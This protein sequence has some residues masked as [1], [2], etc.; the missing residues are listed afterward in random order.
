MWNS[1]SQEG[2]NFWLLIA[3]R[4]RG[5]AGRAVIMNDRRDPPNPSPQLPQHEREVAAVVPVRHLSI[6]ARALPLLACLC[7]AMASSFSSSEFARIFESGSAFGHAAALR[8]LALA[9]AA[10]AARGRFTL[11]LSGGSMMAQLGP[12]LVQAVCFTYLFNLILDL[13]F[14]FRSTLFGRLWPVLSAIL[15][16]AREHSFDHWHIFLADERCVSHE[17][18]DSNFALVK[19]HF[20]DGIAASDHALP[21]ANVRR[22]LEGALISSHLNHSIVLQIHPH[23]YCHR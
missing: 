18:P 12:T 6:F 4:G 14:D 15:L 7:L 13:R 3:A 22:N 2:G 1:I 17:S 23:A 8:L 10:I 9:D 5:A 16:Q 21:E 11:A 19:K 20:L